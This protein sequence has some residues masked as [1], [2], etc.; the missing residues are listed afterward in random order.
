MSATTT[1]EKVLTI[2]AKP[3]PAAITPTSVGKASDVARVTV[4]VEPTAAEPARPLRRDVFCLW[5]W[6][7]CA[8]ILVVYHFQDL[9]RWLSR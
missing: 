3:R 8:A 2:E 1:V 6:V 4:H 9:F 5:F 7:A